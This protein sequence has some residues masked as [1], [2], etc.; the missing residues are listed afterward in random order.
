MY[1]F[2]LFITMKKYLHIILIC[3]F[4]FS[5]CSPGSE[6]KAVLKGKIENQPSNMATIRYWTLENGTWREVMDTCRIVDGQF[7][8]DLQINDVTKAELFFDRNSCAAEIYVELKPMEIKFHSGSI[9]DY[10]ISGSDSDKD[11]KPLRKQISNSADSLNILFF[12]KI[13]PLLQ[14]LEQNPNNEN[15]EVFQ[16][17][18]NRITPIKDYYNNKIIKAN[19]EYIKSHSNSPVAAGQLL[20]IIKL[21]GWE[22]PMDST[23]QLYNELSDEVKKSQL[24]QLALKKIQDIESEKEM[25]EA[26]SIGKTAPGFSTYSL[27]SGD[28]IRLSDYKGKSYVLLDFWSSGCRPCLQSVPFLRKINE[29]YSKK[30]FTIIGI[31]SDYEKDKYLGA[32]EK[33][34]QKDWPQILEVQNLEESLKGYK[35]KE[36]IKEKYYIEAEPTYILIDT[37]GIIIG[38]WIGYNEEIEKEIT[39]KLETIF[40]N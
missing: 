23:K 35:N 6:Q 31:S 4:V 28:T 5:A 26:M 32:I 10:T 9:F 12:D 30:G 25:E 27:I 22:Y 36:D 17:F 14:K 37:N 21:A 1:G 15:L 11:Y 2:N 7:S 39:E 16:E 29:K 40:P 18:T 34:N 33:H 38:K 8:F 24:G 3:I 20:N 19:L 13:R